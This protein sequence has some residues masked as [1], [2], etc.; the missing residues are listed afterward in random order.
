MRSI[1]RETAISCDLTS[2][3]KPPI[4]ERAVP[5]PVEQLELAELLAGLALHAGGGSGLP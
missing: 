5:H 2:R 1:P 3:A 4:P